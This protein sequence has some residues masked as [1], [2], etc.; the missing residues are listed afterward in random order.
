MVTGFDISKISTHQQLYHLSCIPSA[1]EMV[2]KLTNRVGPAFYELQEK[3]GNRIGSFADFDNR[4][5]AGIHF[6]RQFPMARSD[7]FPFGDLFLGI[8][9]ELHAQRYVII[10]LA[11]PG[12]FHMWIIFDHDEENFCALTK[13]GIGNASQTTQTREIKRRVLGMRGTD[14]LVYENM[15]S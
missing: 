6:H 13:D 10:S 14:I 9:E 2:L 7:S 8:V 15:D 12:G 1:V 4:V 3:W 11:S 5:V